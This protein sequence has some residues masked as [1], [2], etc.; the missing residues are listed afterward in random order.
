MGDAAALTLDHPGGD[1]T[2]RTGHRTDL[3]RRAR[4]LFE[5]TE[6]QLAAVGN[7]HA[8]DV[9]HHR[10]QAVIAHRADQ[11]D[12]AALAELVDHRLEARVARLAGVEY[13]LAV[14]VDDR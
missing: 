5:R 2:E 9:E 3:R 14:I 8:V 1:P 11:I 6:R 13:L 12:R 4:G 10:D 7:R